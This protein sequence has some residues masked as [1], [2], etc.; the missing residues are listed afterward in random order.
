LPL[1]TGALMPLSVRA[2][3]LGVIN[4]QIFNRPALRLQL[5]SDLLL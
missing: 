5:E 3:C 4:N 1:Q 2:K